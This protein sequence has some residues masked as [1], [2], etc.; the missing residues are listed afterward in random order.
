MLTTELDHD[1]RQLTTSA[2][3]DLY[4]EAKAALATASAAQDPRGSP[5]SRS[6]STTAAGVWRASWPVRD[7][8][9]PPAR[10]EP[11][12]FIPQH[13]P[14][15]EDLGWAP[16]AAPSA[17][18]AV[19]RA[20]ARRITGGEDPEIRLVRVGDRYVPWYAAQAER[21]LLGRR[22]GTRAVTASPST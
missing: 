12:F 5:S 22:L 1:I 6:S 7:D 19:C 13:G 20:D 9:D 2:P 15:V 4:D 16:P 18:S 8:L 3:L 11:C 21:G 14:A 17:R 10:R